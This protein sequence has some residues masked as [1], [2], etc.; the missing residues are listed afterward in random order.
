MRLGGEM[1]ARRVQQT[2]LITGSDSGRVRGEEE[3]R[4]VL[5]ALQCKVYTCTTYHISE[6]YFC[7]LTN[8][9][10]IYT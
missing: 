6:V 3:E 9:S 2:I 7:I 1:K 8:V 4:C 10:Y 5:Y